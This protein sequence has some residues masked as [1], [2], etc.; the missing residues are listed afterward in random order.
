MLAT[1]AR[2]GNALTRFV[3]SYREVS[4]LPSPLLQ[5]LD[6]TA[7]LEDVLRFMQTG[8]N[9]LYLTAPL[10]RSASWPTRDKWSR[11]SSI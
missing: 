10:P 9:D 3:G 11:Y 7:L 1:I 2:R 8:D 5:P 4:H 6:A